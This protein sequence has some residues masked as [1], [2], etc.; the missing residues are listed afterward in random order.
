MKKTFAFVLSL[1]ITALLFSACGKQKSEDNYNLNDAF[2]AVVTAY[3]EDYIPSMDID[4]TQLTE[5]Y[6]VDMANVEEFRAQAPMISA[7]VDTFIA[8]K[9]VDG[10]AS[11]VE[12][13]LQEYRTYMLNEAMNYPANLP[14]IEAS[15]VSVYGNYV[16]FTM[17]GAF[18]DDMDAT[19]DDLLKFYQN[20]TQKAVDALNTY[21][22]K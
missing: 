15:T 1:C 20:E 7:H 9:A 22:G 5:T 12:K 4:E 2:Q 16:F 13:Q 18:S 3:G 8:I 11:E 6:G 19:E 21:F 17:L 10:K 14:K